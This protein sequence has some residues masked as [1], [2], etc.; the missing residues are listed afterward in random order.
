[1][2]KTGLDGL[3]EC[4]AALDAVGVKSSAAVRAGMGAVGSAGVRFAR[5]HAPVDTLTLKKALGQRVRTYPKTGVTVLV[6]GARKDARPKPGQPAKPAK[7]SRQV[8]RRGSTKTTTATPAYYLHLVAFGTRP[9]A[10]AK[11]D[12]LARPAKAGR[13]AV[14][15]IQTGRVHP[16]TAPDP[17]MADTAK[18]VAATGPPVLV[19][20]V[21]QEIAKLARKGRVR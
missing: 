4:V 12:T 18:F 8:V 10:V 16:G 1:M 17:F 9:H 13:R 5:A 20:R 7:F 21:A 19:G 11:G 6:I 2:A 3:A 14:A 15:H